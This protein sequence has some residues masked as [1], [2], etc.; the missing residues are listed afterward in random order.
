[1]KIEVKNINKSFRKVKVIK[2]V[3][4]T[5]TS[6]K[7]YGIIGPNGSGKSAFLKLLCSFYIPDSGSILQDGYDYIKNNDF[8]KDTRA[9]IEKPNFI[10][11]LT[12][13][14]NLKMLAKL[15]NKIKE[16]DI[17]T[18]LEEVNLLEE[19]DK[20]YYEYS[21]GMKQKLGIAQALME[22][23]KFI[24]LDEPFNGVDDTSV[25]KIKGILK[26]LKKDD[27]IIVITSHI[28]EDILELSDEIYEFNY[29]VLSKYENEK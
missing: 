4:I 10:D 1:M 16:K 6:G 12:G 3:N 11:D 15:Q 20:L 19:K 14:E 7:I 28:K 9:L 5:F 25:K 13:Y 29:G 26:D 2:N 21:L 24:I 22:K 23:P 18:S 17:L 27:R 8:P